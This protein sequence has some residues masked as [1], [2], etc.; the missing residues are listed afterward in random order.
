MDKR[1]Y[2]LTIVSF[3]V[4]MVELIIGGI[5]DLISADLGVSYGQSGRLITIFS[6]VFAISAPIL[7]LLT[8]K[9]ER[10]KLAIM[11]LCVFLVG[12]I[13]S[14]F[15]HTYGMV[16]VSRIIL[17]MS[18]SLLTVLCITL[19]AN[20]V[21][22]RYRGR[23]IGLVVMGISGSLVLGVP[24]GVVL[25]HAFGW[26]SPFILIAVLSV[27]LMVAVYRFMG[28]VA[29]R[30]YA[31]LMMQLTTLKH[32][33]ILF[34]H[35]TTF[36]FLAG[37]FALYGFLTPFAIVTMGFEG[38]WITIMYF[39]F[40]VAAVTGG[41]VGG[42]LA[43]RFGA[44]RTLLAVIVVF[45]ASL[46]A[47]PYT[48]FAVPLFMVMLIIWSVMS[49]AITPTV[50]SYLIQVAPE[51]SD[52]QQ[53]LNNS[54][55]HFGI[56]FGTFVGSLVIEHLAVEHNATAGGLLVLVALLTALLALRRSSG[57]GSGS[58]SGS[59]SGSGSGSTATRLPVR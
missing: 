40:G 16:V 10:R 35:L 44:R 37:H 59:E 39:V 34:S 55:L 7:L 17:A 53:S 43:D 15:S 58:G 45:A 23:A 5:L 28:R 46:F 31:P 12:N 49:W 18:G 51:T 27:L 47:M 56:A 42:M 1:V 26:R 54:A 9:I 25:G 38:N 20:I 2:L 41:G 24:I 52:I 50:Q 36:F 30:P 13:V 19:A 48:T 21:E 57:S 22:A 4:G 29:A 3:I 6:L 8:A 14:V 11:S 32:R 33:K